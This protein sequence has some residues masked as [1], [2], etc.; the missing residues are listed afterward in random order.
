MA[1]GIGFPEIGKSAERESGPEIVER[2]DGG[3][4]RETLR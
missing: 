1:D 3:N 4:P 2:P